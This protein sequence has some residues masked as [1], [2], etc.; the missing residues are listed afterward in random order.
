MELVECLGCF[1]LIE[2][3][4]KLKGTNYKR[5]EKTKD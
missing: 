3:Q 2:K 5:V 1:F 4:N